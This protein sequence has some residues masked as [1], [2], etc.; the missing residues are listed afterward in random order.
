MKKHKKF[1][2][3]GAKLDTGHTNG[4]V[5]AAMLRA[6]LAMGI[7]AYWLDNRD[8]LPDEFFDDAIIFTEQWLVF[9][10]SPLSRLGDR[11]P[12]RKSSTYF[13]NYLGNKPPVE[14]ASV[15][16][17]TSM[18]NEGNPGADMYLGKV[19]KL[20]DYRF[21][22][23][24]GSGEIKDKNWDYKFEKEKYEPL[25]NGHSFYEKGNEYDNIYS[26]WAT[27]LLPHEINYE[28]RFITPAE[29]KYAFFGGTIREENAP[30]FYP[31][32]KACEE[33]NIAFAYN[34]PWTHGQISTDQMRKLVSKSYLAF[35]A[36]FSNML[37]HGFIPCRIF[38]NISYGHLPLTNS[39]AVYDYFDGDVAYAENTYDLFH[40]AV[41]KLHDKDLILR[42]M[43]NVKENHTYINR[44][45][46][47]ITAAEI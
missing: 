21:A 29:P 23:S 32:I 27:D 37:S 26:A 43:V 17:P 15:G 11:L 20:F 4:F 9:P 38:K 3:W 14:G 28:D 47:I 34:C 35:E 22:C 10:G 18:A 44:I 39:K 31:F 8:N 12:L 42:Q 24:W 45:K 6:C 30:Y 40:V 19:G 7:D 41:S 36:R 1:I 33:N 16:L 5:H 25:N 2:I 46:D 13:I